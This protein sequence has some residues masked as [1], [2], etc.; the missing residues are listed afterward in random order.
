MSL[1]SLFNLSGKTALI[2][3]S[4]KGIGKAYAI[5]LAEA[6]ADIIGA[7][8]TTE[9]GSD[10]EKVKA[11]G[12]PK[13]IAAGKNLPFIVVSPQCY[14]PVGWDPE[15][16]YR[17]LTSVKKTYRVDNDRVYLTGLSMGGFGTWTLAMKHPEEFAA[18][19]PICGGGDTTDQEVSNFGRLGVFDPLSRSE[20]EITVLCN[21]RPN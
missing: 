13:L 8:R 12:P 21:Q 2:T 14:A 11:H 3:G 5:A 20:A 18:L 10:L 9:S 19:L 7:S 15:T 4:D 1:Q 6:G 16:L 17:L